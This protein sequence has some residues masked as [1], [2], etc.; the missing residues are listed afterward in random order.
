M[1]LTAQQQARLD[2][3][4][5]VPRPGVVEAVLDSEAKAGRL[6]WQLAPVMAERLR[7][8]YPKIME[9]TYPEFAAANGKVLPIDSS[10]NPADESW[11]YFLIDGQ[12]SCAWIGDD[13]TLAP[14]SSMTMRQFDGKFAQFGHKWDVT[15]FDLERAAKANVPLQTF[16]GKLSKKAHEAWKNWFWLF[17]SKSH[18]LEGLVNNPNVTHFLAA[19]NGGSTSRLWANKTDDEILA[20]V[21]KMIDRIPTDTIREHYAAKVFLSLAMVQECM[22]RYLASTAS[23]TVTLWDR[24]KHAYAGDETG[25]GKVSFQILNEC[26][27]ALRKNPETR[28]D[29]SGISGDF[30]MALPSDD[31]DQLAFLSARPF[32][33]EAPQQTD[34]KIET[35]THE[36]IGGCKCQIPKAVVV[37]R[38]GT[39]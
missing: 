7:H 3:Y 31:S 18:E 27:A 30:M 25:Q 4:K 19:Q 20:D 9:A 32:S 17:G 29:D 22:R 8:V 21:A 36:K 15:V 14:S 37:M 16:K 28:T 10:P 39:T 1:K 12:A 13:G 6:D 23:G 26:S 38:F 35:I 33:Q 5:L 24:I 2:S 34:L 11:R